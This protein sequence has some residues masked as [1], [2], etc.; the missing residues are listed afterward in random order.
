MA[1]NI[2]DPSLK[3]FAKWRNYPSILVIAL[4][5]KNKAKLFFNFVSKE[6][7]L[8]DVLDVSKAIQERNI[9]FKIMKADENFFAEAY[10]FYSNKLLENCKFPGYL[11]LLNIKKR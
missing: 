5:Y 2:D 7:V 4:E 3:A 6:N 1:E 8:T 11:K 10:C 9:P